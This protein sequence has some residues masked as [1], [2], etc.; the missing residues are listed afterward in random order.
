MTWNKIAKRITLFCF[1]L[2]VS[3]SAQAQ[4]SKWEFSLDYSPDNLKKA[5]S[6]S[7]SKKQLNKVYNILVKR[8]LS[9]GLSI[10]Q[11]DLSVESKGVNLLMDKICQNQ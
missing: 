9:F 1:F 5:Y 2:S 7:I 11:F 8:L 10:D 4:I 6:D 3:L